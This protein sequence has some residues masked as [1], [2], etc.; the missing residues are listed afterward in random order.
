[1]SIRQRY[2]TRHQIS[3]DVSVREQRGWVHYKTVDVSRRGVFLRCESPSPLNRLVQMRVEM[4]TGV[5][6]DVMGRVRRSL[7]SR[8]EG[9]VGPGMGIEFFVMSP[10]QQKRLG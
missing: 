10:A 2:Y 9:P 1:M 6:L 3:L 5:V 7:Q 4:P 8:V